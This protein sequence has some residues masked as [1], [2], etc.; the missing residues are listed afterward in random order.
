MR[1]VEF[2]QE[3]ILELSLNHGE[4]GAGMLELLREGDGVLARDR[5]EVLAQVG[6]EVQGDLLRF[7]RVL[8]AEVIDARHRV[9]DEVGPHL[10]H[11]DARALIG[12]LLLLTDVL[13]NLVR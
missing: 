11:R 3:I 9:V 7:F 10:Q 12:D 8:L 1:G 2:D 5:V 13:L 4:V 6:G